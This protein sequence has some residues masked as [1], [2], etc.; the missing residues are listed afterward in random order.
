MHGLE[1]ELRQ[2]AAAL[3]A[4]A[5][6][7]VGPSHADD[8]VQ[9]TSLLAW[10]QRPDERGGLGGWLRSVLRHRAGKLQRGSARRTRREQVAAHDDVAP[11]PLDVAAQREAM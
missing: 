4:L 9:E 11:S 3:R 7:L 2:H 6:R 1:H 5:L 10:A 8:L